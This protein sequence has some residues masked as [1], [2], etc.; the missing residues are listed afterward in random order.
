MLLCKP[1]VGALANTSVLRAAAP[2]DAGAGSRR[3][4]RAQL[5]LALL[6]QILRFVAL[7]VIGARSVAVAAPAA[8]SADPCGVV[9]RCPGG[10]QCAYERCS[11]SLCWFISHAT[12]CVTQRCGGN[13]GVPPCR[14]M[15]PCCSVPWLLPAQQEAP[16]CSAPDPTHCSWG[17]TLGSSNSWT[18]LSLVQIANLVLPTSQMVAA[19][20][21][22]RAQSL[23]ELLVAPR[24]PPC[25][26]A[27]CCRTR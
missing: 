16:A 13:L 5:L 11:S 21:P 19:C 6:L 23:C 18:G 8:P 9:A 27:G 15:W 22:A 24:H 1:W 2:L 26:C 14:F 20:V 10:R 17:K 4:T 12:L 3:R 25:R 7:P